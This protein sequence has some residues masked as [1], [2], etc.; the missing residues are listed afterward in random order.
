M[1]GWS[2]A[3][4]PGLETFE[5]IAAEAYAG[6]PA[7]FREA[8]GDVLIAVADFPDAD[9]VEDMKLGSG[10]DILGLFEGVGLTERSESEMPALPNRVWLYRRPILD[11]WAEHDEEL[12]HVIRHVLIHELGHH[13]G[14]SDADMDRLETMAG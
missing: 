6:L 3:R 8:T 1:T 4:A 12:G 5:A 13:F 10:F 7:A 2:K 14:F 11:Y 9:T